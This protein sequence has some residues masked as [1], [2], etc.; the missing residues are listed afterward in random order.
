MG[1][2][3]LIWT[4]LVFILGTSL[5]IPKTGMA[6]SEADID[7]LT[8][9]AVIIGRAIACGVDTNDAM[10]R[11][12]A[13]MDRKFPPGSSD[14]KTYLP[15]FMNGVEYHAAQQANGKS[16][17]TCAQVKSTFRKMQWP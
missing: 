13:W 10:R 7:R 9:Y 4:L 6:A 12:G 15:I 3:V 11:V 8:T 5:F 1:K 16:P 17:D 14:Q 2:I